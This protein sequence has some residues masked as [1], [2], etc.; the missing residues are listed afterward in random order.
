MPEAPLLVLASGSPRRRRVLESLGI[1]FR[2]VV[3][4]IDETPLAG[5]SPEACC[6][7]LARAKAE[8]ASARGPSP[9]VYLAADTLVTLE[10]SIIGKPSDPEDALSILRRLSGVRHRVVSAVSVL[11]MPSGRERSE[12]ET[13]E[14]EMRRLSE[15]EMREYVASGEPMGRAGAYSVEDGGARFVTRVEGSFSNV[16]GLPVER[17]KRLLEEFGVRV[18]RSA[19]R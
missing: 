10:G 19:G 6:L 14:V 7:R 17:V 11:E 8:A 12:V 4:E 2:L 1:A 3:P 15:A 18:S 5:E 9:A 13:S 16:V